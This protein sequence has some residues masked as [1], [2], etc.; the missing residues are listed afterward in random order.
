MGSSISHIPSIIVLDILNS[1]NAKLYISVFKP[2]C[3]TSDG[4]NLLE[5]ACQSEIYLSQISSG[6]ILKWLGD[7][8][9]NRV[10]KIHS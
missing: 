2:D 6:L 3:K 10:K 8:I 1:G 7:T 5:L 4:Y 9:V